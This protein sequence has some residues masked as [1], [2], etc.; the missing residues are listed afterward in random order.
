MIEFRDVSKVYEN[1]TVG[2]DHVNLSIQ[3]C[4][5]LAVIGLSGAGKSTMLRSINRL[6][7][8]SEGEIFVD[9]SSIT[10]ASR[11]QLRKMRTRIGMISQ[12]FNL[13]KRSTVQRNV[14]SGKLGSFGTVKSIFGLFSQADYDLCT[15]MLKKVGLEKKLH[16]RCDE[17]SGGQQQRVSIARTL[18][19]EADIILA[20]EPVAS[21]DPV[22]SKTIMEDLKKINTEMNKTIVINIHSVSLAREYATRIIG[23]RSGKIVFDGTPKEL[24]EEKLRMIYQGEEK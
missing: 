4:E 9:G 17:L 24:N 14:L 21:L 2:L 12:T 18:F 11:K 3:D 15:E 8:I 23:M 7:E 1:G 10:K 20:D 16:S 5:F 19:Q 13:G 6:N 22:T